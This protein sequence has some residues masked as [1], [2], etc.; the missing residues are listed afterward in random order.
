MT[1]ADRL[2]VD[3]RAVFHVRVQ[4]TCLGLGHLDN[5]EISL[6]KKL[7]TEAAV[8]FRL[9][10]EKLSAT[11]MLLPTIDELPVNYKQYCFRQIHKQEINKRVNRRVKLFENPTLPMTSPCPNVSKR[12]DFHGNK[13]WRLVLDFYEL[14]GGSCFRRLKNS[15]FFLIRESI[16]NI[17]KNMYVKLYRPIRSIFEDTAL[18]AVGRRAG[19]RALKYPARLIDENVYLRRALK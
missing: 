16:P 11:D 17:S 13:K 2:G 9:P 19:I 1:D 18:N 14:K 6:V 5:N 10:G 7:I 4:Q 15:I 12:N 3:T 8:I